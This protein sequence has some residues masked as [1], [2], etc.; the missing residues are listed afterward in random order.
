M[1]IINACFQFVPEE[2]FYNFHCVYKK[3][4]RKL[5]SKRKYDMCVLLLSKVFNSIRLW[6][7]RKNWAS[8]QRMPF[9]GRC[10]MIF[11]VGVTSI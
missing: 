6:K 3:K 4:V 5:N 2:E 7:S 10:E 1:K 9:A 11:V 8:K